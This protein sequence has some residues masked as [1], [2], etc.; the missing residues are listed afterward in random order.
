MSK[1]RKPSTARRIAR[2]VARLLPAVVTAGAVLASTGTA[3]AGTHRDTVANDQRM[4]SAF[5]A[6]ANHDGRGDAERWAQY[7]PGTD[8][9]L[10][11]DGLTFAWAI[12]HHAPHPVL[13]NTFGYVWADCQPDASAKR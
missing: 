7:L 10:Y 3:G 12:E 6:W 9:Y 4:C 8:G 1:H 5:M 11:R 13:S 2:K